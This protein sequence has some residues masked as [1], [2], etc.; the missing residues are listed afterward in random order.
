[1][2]V[3]QS[4]AET[5]K[6]NIADSQKARE[7]RAHALKGGYNYEE[8]QREQEWNSMSDSERRA[9][10]KTALSIDTHPRYGKWT[11]DKE[12]VRVEMNAYYEIPLHGACL[13]RKNVEYSPKNLTSPKSLKFF[14]VAQLV[15]F[16]ASLR[17]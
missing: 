16:P 15:T 12:N 2:R 4:R 9:Y 8:W 7:A 14:H 1:M 5:I 11:K 13:K 3:E 17:T 6:Q 10:V